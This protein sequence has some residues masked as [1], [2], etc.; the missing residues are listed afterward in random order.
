MCAYWL[1]DTSRLRMLPLESEKEKTITESTSDIMFKLI[2][3]LYIF[4]CFVY[5]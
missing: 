5:I 1:L 4:Y 3:D 2:L